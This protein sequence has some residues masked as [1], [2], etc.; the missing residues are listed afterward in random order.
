M[1]S[2]KNR[3]KRNRSSKALF[4]N[5]ALLENLEPRLML[6][7]NLGVVAFN[8]SLVSNHD[9]TVQ[10]SS[11]GQT[12]VFDGN[13]TVNGNLVISGA[14]NVIFEG[15]VDVTGNA[16]ITAAGTISFANQFDIGQSATLTAGQLD[17]A[18]G[19]GSVQAAGRASTLTVKAG[20][21]TASIFVGDQADSSAGLDLTSADLAAIASG[22]QDIVIGGPAANNVTVGSAAFSNSVSIYG[23]SI[24][25]LTRLQDTAGKSVL[26]DGSTV[27]DDGLIAT[28]S[29]KVTLTSTAL[30]TVAAGGEIDV[31]GAVDSSAG[32]I[33]LWSGAD[34]VVAGS[35]AARGGSLGG[36]GGVIDASTAGALSIT[37]SI[38]TQASAGRAGEFLLDPHNV[39]IGAVDDGE[40][41]TDVSSFSNNPATDYHVSAAVLEGWNSNVVIQANTDITVTSAISMGAGNSLTLQAGRSVTINANITTADQAIAITANDSGAVSADRDAGVANITMAA[42]TTLNSGSGTIS[43]TIDAGAV[44]TAGA[45]GATGANVTVNTTG[46]LN[47]QTSDGN[48]FITAT[49]PGGVTLGTVD[50]GTGSVILYSPSF[51]AGAGM[52]LTASVVG[53]NATGNSGA[54]GTS[55]NP[56]LTNVSLLGAVTYDGGIYIT[57]QGAFEIGAVTARQGGKTPYPSGSGPIVVDN[58][59]TLGTW[60]VTILAGGNILLDTVI[61]P[62]VATI[63]ST[64]GTIYDGTGSSNNVTAQTVNLQATG[65]IGQ[66]TDAITTTNETISA[67]STGGSIYLTEGQT[68]TLADVVAQNN[69]VITTSGGTLN[70]GTVTNLS[71]SGTVTLTTSNG[72]ILDASGLIT[73]GTA[74]LSA[75][76]AIGS[77]ADPVN[78]SVANLSATVSGPKAPPVYVND[79]IT[80]TSVSVTTNNGPVTVTYSGGSLT[81]VPSTSLLSESGASTPAVTFDNTGGNLVLATLD[82][83]TAAV[84]LTASGAITDLNNTVLLTGG[85]VTLAGTAIGTA[86]ALLDTAATV[87]ITAKASAGSVYIDNDLGGT[88]TLTATAKGA[89]NTVDVSNLGGGVTLEGVSASGPVILSA[90]GSILDGTSNAVTDI[91]GS[92]ATLTASGAIGVSTD[93]VEMAVGTVNATASGGAAYLSDTG[94]LQAT[95]SALGN[96]S[97]SVTGSLTIVGAFTATGGTA[98]LAATGAII[99][100]AAGLVTANTASLTGSKIGAAGTPLEMAV[101][102]L[103][104]AETI[105]GGIYIVNAGGL[106]ID[107]VTSLGLSSDINIDTSGNMVLGQVTAAGN[108]VVL[109]SDT[110]SITGGN[111]TGANV[112]AKTLTIT[113]PGG[114]GTST[115]PLQLAVSQLDANGGSGGVWANSAVA[116]ALTASSLEGKG[117]AAVV[118]NAPAITVLDMGGSVAELDMDGSVTLT[119]TTGNIVFLDLHDTI[120]TQGTGTIT[121][122]AGTAPGSG[123]VAIVGNLT[124]HNQAI[125]VTADSNVILGGELN[126]GTGHVTVTARS[127]Q[128]VGSSTPAVNIIAGAETLTQTPPTARQAQLTTIWAIGNST[129]A[130]AQATAELSS[131]NSFASAAYIAEQ[132]QSAAAQTYQ[133]DVTLV[134][135]AQAQADASQGLATALDLTSTILSGIST[136]LAVAADAVQLIGAAAQAIPITGD[137]GSMV[138]ATII[139]IVADG[140]AAA[141]YAA[142]VAAS[143]ADNNAGNDAAALEADQAQEYA[144]QQTLALA[145]STAEAFQKSQS[146]AT[147]DANA[148]A[149]AS[150]AAAVVA[151]WDTVAEDQLNGTPDTAS[152]KLVLDTAQVAGVAHSNT[153]ATAMNLGTVST[154]CNVV[155]T[156]SASS[157]TNWYKFTLSAPADANSNI[158]VA[159]TGA[160]GQ[161]KAALY[162]TTGVVTQYSTNAVNS[163]TLSLAGL[164]AGTYYV[165]VAGTDPTGYTMQITPAAPAAIIPT[166]TGVA[167]S[168]NTFMDMVQVTW[169]ASTNATAYD[170]YRSTT[171]VSNT[172][173]ILNNADITTTTYNDTTAVAGTTYY[174]WVVARNAAG[175]SGYSVSASGVCAALTAP[176]APTS[177]VASAN[178]YTDR[179]QVTWAAP[180]DAAAFDV[181]RNTANNFGAATKLNAADI[182]ATAYGDTTAVAGTPY[183]YWVVARNGAGSSSPSA[184]AIGVRGPATVT[185]VKPNYTFATAQNLGT[186]TTVTNVA[187]SLTAANHIDWYQFTLSAAPDAGSKITASFTG[188]SGQV[189]LVIESNTGV[190]LRYATAYAANLTTLS[191]TGLAAGAYRVS[192]YGTAVARNYTMQIMPTVA[193]TIVTGVAASTNTITNAVQVTWT[194]GLGNPTA[195][196]VYRSVINDPT[197]ALKINKASVTTTTYNDTTAVVGATYY[198]WVVARNAVGSSGFSTSASGVRAAGS[199]LLAQLTPNNTF[200]TAQALGTI[201]SPTTVLGALVSATDQNWYQFTLPA[202]G[203]AASKIQVSFTGAAGQIGA[204]IESNTG[205]ILRYATASVANLT[206]LSLTGLAAG[207]YRVAIYGSAARSY[208]ALITP[209]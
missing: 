157:M 55:A 102:T 124:T 81:F 48:I 93:V 123:A 196:D 129:A 114:I 136:G 53:F 120:Q 167:A 153:F 208:S 146:I 60:D 94:N 138:A 209:S 72:A 193:P 78:T 180:N 63:S 156:A 21:A 18:G 115:T 54:I 29:G 166:P 206:T 185:E 95:V 154:V 11:P 195:Y 188:A 173:T 207:T 46:T 40:G 52:L 97:L 66:S 34:T 168:N 10:A 194:A 108:N 109:T 35:L 4:G 152:K 141:A 80:P 116:L 133:Q 33:S 85:A 70:V 3:D 1:A 45:I 158:Q 175:S 22:F 20:S 171:N 19:T 12:I 149:I 84:S 137:G 169:A 172:A 174:Y 7:T 36:D 134:N 2:R 30:T 44:G 8:D 170:V 144:D 106:I 61:A 90:G 135:Q 86:G 50:A 201:S 117:T 24:T 178:T 71:G 198:Y 49:A 105:T 204:V 126:A 112:T 17:F 131:E 31:S 159:F 39:T 100:G 125:T 51:A 62:D 43:L 57:N 98:T 164:A 82:A 42:G 118:F 145:A 162:N 73:A 205:V 28:A 101:S 27:T 200:A 179:V 38:D 75:T 99:E 147:A 165:D 91:T 139:H 148:S 69:V 74:D 155:G 59:G 88:I 122:N 103:A 37:G 177:V 41:Q 202:A 87:S 203:D 187:G 23:K 163:A 64:G 13:L 140:V 189:G 142:Q 6:A 132:A 47:A 92:S 110:G 25:V 151:Q 68:A 192:T 58:S 176:A 96:L 111:G 107:T 77:S 143:V 65:D 16:A 83:G 14:Q 186:I 181:Y 184:S 161:V 128:I 26:L 119:T 113:A 9:L 56:I 183:Y 150:S 160:S 199:A 89:G 127:G 121:I 15:R 191:L 182:T 190:I 197:A 79:A 76:T 130:Q 32:T 67:T 5:R 104:L